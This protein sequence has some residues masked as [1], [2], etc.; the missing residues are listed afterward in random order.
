[1]F[2]HCSNH[3]TSLDLSSFNTSNVKDMS[4]MFYGYNSLTSLDLSSFDTSNVKNM[5]AMFYGC[6]EK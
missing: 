2:Y 3:L 6:K 5:T 4:S 1:M